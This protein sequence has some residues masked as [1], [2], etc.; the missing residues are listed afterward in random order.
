MAKMNVN[1]N[2]S[3][4]VA[5]F[6]KMIVLEGTV[7]SGKTRTL[8][9][10]CAKLVS[11]G[12]T[13]IYSINNKNAYNLQKVQN[14]S[15]LSDLGLVFEKEGKYIFVLTAGDILCARTTS[16]W[17]AFTYAM[18]DVF[19][20]PHKEL[21]EI[22]KIDLVVCA[23]RSMNRRN[24]VKWEID[25]NYSE[26]IVDRFYTQWSAKNMWIQDRERLADEIMDKINEV[27]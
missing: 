3:Q 25:R 14:A 8:N 7:N 23:C 27:I 6:D 21:A 24:S 10:L 2:V 13:E 15:K 22:K 16:E 9:F 12:W 11:A 4:I 1:Y 17:Y 5:R 19:M 18:S 26:K 20:Q